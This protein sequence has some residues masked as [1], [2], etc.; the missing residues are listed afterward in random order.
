M[1]WV[2]AADRADAPPQDV[3]ATPVRSIWI[4]APPAG[5]TAAL[6]AGLPGLGPVIRCAGTGPLRRIEQQRAT[7]I[8]GLHQLRAGETA[9]HLCV[10]DGADAGGRTAVAAEA[11]RRGLEAG[12][13][14]AA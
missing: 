8:A 12:R 14:A 6:E 10:A 4:D 11:L 13:G 1:V 3:A 2:A 7:V 5:A 9:L